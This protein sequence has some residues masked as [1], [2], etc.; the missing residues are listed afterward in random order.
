M[1]CLYFVYIWLDSLLSCVTVIK[2]GKESFCFRGQLRSHLSRPVR[3]RV[4]VRSNSWLWE[5][6]KQ[7]LFYPKKDKWLSCSETCCSRSCV[8]WQRVDLNSRFC[9]FHGPSCCA[10]TPHTAFH[11]TEE[12]NSALHECL[13]AIRGWKTYICVR[14]N[15]MKSNCILCFDRFVFA[16]VNVAL[17]CGLPACVSYVFAP[18]EYKNHSTR[19]NLA[20]KTTAG[21]S[22]TWVCLVTQSWSPFSP[23]ES[24]ALSQGAKLC[25]CLAS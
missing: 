20:R 5:S 19:T 15:G 17:H 13:N 14:L 23:W 22:S 10:F 4:L 25:L 18:S 9:M 2:R 16:E 3:W 21:R 6:E 1:C 8:K 24:A 11:E 7:V 12:P